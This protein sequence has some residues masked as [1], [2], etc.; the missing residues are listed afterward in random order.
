MTDDQLEQPPTVASPASGQLD[1]PHDAPDGADS[2]APTRGD[3]SPADRNAAGRPSGQKRRRGSRGGRNRK[4]PAT[5][6][7]EANGDDAEGVV[8]GAGVRMVRPEDT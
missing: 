7:L 3:G 6:T 4:K 5:I 1:S 8:A 2:S